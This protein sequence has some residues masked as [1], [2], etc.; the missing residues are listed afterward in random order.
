[1]SLFLCMVRG[2]ILA[3]LIYMW[4]SYFPVFP[5][6]LAVKNPPAMKEMQE[7]Q[8]WSLGWEDPL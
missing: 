4:L 6:G 7:I 5:N 8:V 2:Y 1:M 3:S